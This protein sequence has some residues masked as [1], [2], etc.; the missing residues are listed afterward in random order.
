MKEDIKQLVASFRQENKTF[1]SVRLEPITIDGSPQGFV[2]VIQA[3]WLAAMSRWD[4]LKAIVDKLYYLRDAG[5]IS[6]DTLKE[7]PWVRIVQKQLQPM[8]PIDV[9]A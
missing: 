7:I 3:D 5:T 1:N 4:A 6:N 8:I 2:L 9:L